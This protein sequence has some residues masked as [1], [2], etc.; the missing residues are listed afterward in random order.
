M[1]DCGKDLGLAMAAHEEG[2]QISDQ[3][4][5]ILTFHSYCSALANGG[6]TAVPF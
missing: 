4:P 3:L 6:G 2:P 5:E 1:L